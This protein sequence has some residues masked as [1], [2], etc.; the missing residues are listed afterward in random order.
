MYI[1]YNDYLMHHGVK[2]MKWGIRH[3][4]IP[5]GIRQRTTRSSTKRSNRNAK[6]WIKRGAIAAGIVL[7]GAAAGYL[8]KNGKVS[9]LAKAGTKVAKSDIL[10]ASE[11]KNTVQKVLPQSMSQMKKVASNLNPS[12]STTNCGSCASSMIARLTG[13][14]P[15][16][17]ALSEVPEHM[18]I[19]NGKGYDPEK[20]IDCFEGAKWHPVDALENRKAKSN[21]LH[22]SLL[23]QGEGSS[24]IF[25]F[26]AMTRN[27]PGHYFCYHVSGGKVHVL[28]G[29]PPSGQDG[30]VYTSSSGNDLYDHIGKQMDASQRVRYTRLNDCPIK[31]GRE[32][33]LYR[34]K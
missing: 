5:T 6:K 14:A 13:V 24:G 16:A 27:R 25:Y 7:G 12:G 1:S 28:E 17:Q 11:V 9:E 33:D 21:A 26:D 3:D 8:V 4:Y 29:Q 31:P 30:I 10:G 20:L 32:K 19:P 34:I 23:S 2:G 22:D 15:N 18:R